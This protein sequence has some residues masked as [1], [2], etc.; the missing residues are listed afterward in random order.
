M[1]GND[2][3]ERLIMFDKALRS[4]CAPSSDAARV[5]EEWRREVAALRSGVNICK[6]RFWSI[7]FGVSVEKHG[8][9]YV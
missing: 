4:L 6:V 8:Y 5:K 1:T 2:I 7:S 3:V 9:A